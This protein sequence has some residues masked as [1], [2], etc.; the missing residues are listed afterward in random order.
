MSKIQGFKSYSYPSFFLNLLKMMI[1]VKYIDLPR[2][3][4]RFFCV[5]EY[6]PPMRLSYDGLIFA[7]LIGNYATILWPQTVHLKLVLAEFG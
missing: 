6:T 3:Y 2:L 7:V 5:S 1:L 4:L